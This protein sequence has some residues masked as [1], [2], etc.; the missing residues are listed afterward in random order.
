M[1]GVFRRRISVCR[2]VP[3]ARPDRRGANARPASRGDGQSSRGKAAQPSQAAPSRKGCEK[4]IRGSTKCPRCTTGER[5]RDVGVRDHRAGIHAADRGQ[6]RDHRR[7]GSERAAF[8]SPWRGAGGGAGA[9]R[10]PAFRRRQSQPVLFAWFQ[11]RSWHRSLDQDRRH[12]RQHADPWPRAG[13]CRYQ[14]HDS[15][16]D[17]VGECPQG[18]VLRRRRRL[19]LRRCDRHRLHQPAAEE[20]SGDH[21][22]HLR[23]SPWTGGGVG[24]GRHWHTARGDRGRQIQRPVGRARQRAQDQRRAALQPGHRDRRVHAV[25]DGLF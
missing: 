23:L 17:P 3:G 21:Q 6:C 24:R 22:R 13:L 20:H 1:G 5:R 12:A 8:L 7:R 25:G 19:R 15:R 10:H 9:D 11:S 4:S 2:G 18:T 16:T 14:F